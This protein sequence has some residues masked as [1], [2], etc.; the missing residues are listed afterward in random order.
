MEREA[1]K[2]TRSQLQGR[3]LINHKEDNKFHCEILITGVFKKRVEDVLVMRGQVEWKP[4]TRLAFCKLRSAF[5][6]LS[7]RY[8]RQ[9]SWLTSFPGAIWPVVPGG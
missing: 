8:W 7:A 2:E 1:R 4:V 9:Y 3:D 5:V 6:T